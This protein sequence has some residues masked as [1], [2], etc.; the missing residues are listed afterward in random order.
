[1]SHQLYSFLDSTTANQAFANIFG[2]DAIAEGDIQIT[3][4][5]GFVDPLI[6]WTSSKT[7]TVFN[8]S[9]GALIAT[10][11][12]SLVDITNGLTT[13]SG[14]AI[15]KALSS[16]VAVTAGTPISICAV[17]YGTDKFFNASGTNAFI[18]TDL[19]AGLISLTG[20]GR[21]GSDTVTLPATINPDT[22]T[23]TPFSGPT[24][25]YQ[26]PASSLVSGTLALASSSPAGIDL[27]VTG[28]TGGTGPYST[29][30]Y[31]STTSGFTPGG[32]NSIGSPVTGPSPSFPAV[33]STTTG[34][35]NFFKAATTDSAGSPATVTTGQVAASKQGAPPILALIG[36]SILDPGQGA[37]EGLPYWTPT[38]IQRALGQN[39]GCREVTIIN[40]AASGTDSG[41]W[42]A[43]GSRF[44]T[45][46]A[47][48]ESAS[49]TAVLVQLGTNDVRNPANTYSAGHRPLGTATDGTT[50]GVNGSYARNIA[51]IVSALVT[52]GL[53]VYLPGVPYFY[54][55]SSFSGVVWDD[56]SLNLAATYNTFLTGLV[57]G[58]HVFGPVTST[59]EY[60]ANNPGE[61]FHENG[62]SGVHPN[63][64]GVDSYGVIHAAGFA[65][66]L[67]LAPT[68][69]G[70]F[71]S[72][73]CSFIKGA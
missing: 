30:L 46:L 24:I 4:L 60:F 9:T 11:T 40:Q 57:D 69:S 1:M 59:F 10:V 39:F 13:A 17:G 22:F 68:G 53:K 32:G 67:G 71:A 36:D 37:T 2:L 25:V 12:I 26:S 38:A 54:P 50:A 73:G 64:Q 19:D 16:P 63:A 55:T 42:F 62:A 45:A 28:I 66:V 35:V 47:A 20:F 56:A 6:P 65:R 31:G 72:I 61:F 21:T 43:G 41:D 34:V 5:G 49:A 70:S 48:I 33:T 3:A 14:Q 23:A 15:L 18:T 52:A 51:G 58:V 8:T 44:A 29:Q 7:F 27:T